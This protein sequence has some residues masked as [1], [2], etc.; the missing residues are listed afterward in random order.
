MSGNE[1]RAKKG[2]PDFSLPLGSL[3]ESD[4]GKQLSS[5]ARVPIDYVVEVY[6]SLGNLSKS[7]TLPNTPE[8]IELSRPLAG[9]IRHTL[10]DQPIRQIVESK[11]R[12]INI[13]GRSGIV[14]RQGYTREGNL[15]FQDGRDI[16]LEFDAF[17]QDY[18]LL[19][20]NYVRSKQELSATTSLK[21]PKMIFRA[22]FE[23]INLLVEPQFWAWQRSADTSRLSYE[24]SLS[25]TAYGF[26]DEDGVPENVFSPLDEYAEMVGNAINVAASATATVA[27]ITTNLRGDIKALVS[28]SLNAL[29]NVGLSAQ[30]LA[31]ATN[32]LLML[33]KEIL[34][35]YVVAAA[36]FYDAV[37]MFSQVTN[38]F[39]SDT[40][41][42]EMET[43]RGILGE[44]A[45]EVERT[46]FQ[47]L[48]CT[49][50]GP[51]DVQQARYNLVTSD[52]LSPIKLNASISK[53]GLYSVY[54]SRTGDTLLNLARRV[55][56]D[57]S[58]WVF[59]ARL[60]N[61]EDAH[62]H[63]NGVL[64]PGTRLLLPASID[65]NNQAVIGAK[66][67]DELLGTDLAVN[68]ETGDLVLHAGDL[69]VTRGTLNLEQAIAIRLLTRNGTLV[70][71]PDYGLPIA[72]GVGMT[73]RVAAYAGLHCKEQ[74]L[75]D[76]RVSELRDIEV[77]DEGDRLSVF[78]TIVPINGGS[79][80]FV[81][82]FNT[83]R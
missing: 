64:T 34:A 43:L 37:E 16:C 12:S 70:L 23:K 20:Q 72:P 19:Q 55:L 51:E 21:Q 25:F 35:N 83:D 61:F 78:M 24:W 76:P 49:G 40:Y 38:P 27:S 4:I 56:G 5:L 3:Y 58:Q 82:P 57:A 59:I 7:I 36:T 26:A 52:V 45:N 31:T 68:F 10:G 77:Q 67:A 18:T 2:L 41:D 44:T 33:P 50:G 79:M 32:R 15:K 65:L 66:S 60:N 13:E 6:D 75:R 71:F 81:A 29:R 69:A 80:D 73:S 54:V 63:E 1:P 14:P 46:A 42:T 22:F 11:N 8:S 9:S 47:G 39:D 17:L 62:T 48:F 30:G 74:A 28:P 53:R